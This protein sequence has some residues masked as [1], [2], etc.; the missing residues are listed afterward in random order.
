MGHKATIEQRYTTN[1]GILP[2]IMMKEMREAF[3][4]SEELLDLE[5]QKENPILK[6]KE[7]MQDTIQKA[8]PEE[9]GQMLE[10]FQKLNIG[11]TDQVKG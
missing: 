10:M 8:T 1:K 11:K 3:T 2:E 5:L 7:E 4:R 6:L 9:L